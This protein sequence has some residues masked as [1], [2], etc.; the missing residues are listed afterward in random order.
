VSI[1]NKRF[2][3]IVEVL[4]TAILMGW[5]AAPIASAD[6]DKSEDDKSK[7]IRA[8]AGPSVAQVVVELKS[9]EGHGRAYVVDPAGVLLT[10][11]HVIKWARLKDFKRVYVTFPTDRDK[12]QYL[13]ES[14]LDVKPSCDLVA[15][16]FKPGERKCKALK[17]AENLPKPRETV[18]T[19]GPDEIWEREDY[20]SRG[21]VT[22]IRTGREIDRDLSNMG[23]K[24]F[25]EKQLG[26]SL[27]ATWIQHNAA[28]W[29]GGSGTPVLNAR[30][31]VVG[32]ATWMLAPGERTNC[33]ISSQDIR[34]FLANANKTAKPW[35]QLPK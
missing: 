17:L 35:S 2:C 34:K 29:P 23:L 3:G 10:N 8:A 24:G 18:V 16:R 33:A 27:D 30:A 7:A 9:G 26:Y 13:V 20:A 32:L 25:Y 22:A 12:K 6:D 28:M 31:E 21:T 4:A 1:R 19:I 15:L 5:I 14:W 11:A